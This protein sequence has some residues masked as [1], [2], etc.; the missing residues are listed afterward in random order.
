MN[1]LTRD[2]ILNRALDMVDSPSLDEK[3][4]PAGTIVS[5]ALSIGWLQDALDLWHNRFPWAGIVTST[6]VTFAVGND[7][8]A[9]PPTFIMDVREGVLITTAGKLRRL[10]RWPLQRFV[11]YNLHRS[12]PG[13]P[14][15]YVILPPNLRVWPTPDVAYSGTLWYYSLPAVLAAGTVP[16][17]PSDWVL[18]E[19]VRLRGQEWIDKVPPGT[20]LKYA[21]DR[22]RGLLASG[23]GHEPEDDAIPLDRDRYGAQGGTRWEWM[24]RTTV[25]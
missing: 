24:G 7:T 17:F 13:Q 4:R 2:S 20:A 14:E 10:G 16:N 21:E 18:V 1:R 19:Y 15:R 6:P 11:T 8:V 3:D 25:E 9:L 22:I 23:L 12:T 5:T